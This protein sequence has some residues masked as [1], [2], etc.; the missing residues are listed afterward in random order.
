MIESHQLDDFVGVNVLHKHFD[1]NGNE[2]LVEVGEHI[3]RLLL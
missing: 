2:I 3:E 1:L